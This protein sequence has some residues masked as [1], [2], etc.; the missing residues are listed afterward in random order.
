VNQENDHAAAILVVDDE[1]QLLR[2]L[3]RVLE[4]IG[5]RVYSAADGDEAL[6]VFAE[7]RREIGLAVLDVN[8]PPN[9]VGTL[10]ERMLELREDLQVIMTSGDALSSELRE[11]LSV[12]HGVF[13]RKPFVPKAV[14]RATRQALGVEGE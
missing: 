9:G 8:I 11:R 2:L 13:L 3:V 7:H 14:L 4:R 10:L 6:A 1:P 12:C 5:S